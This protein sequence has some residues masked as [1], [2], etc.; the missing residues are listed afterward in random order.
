MIRKSFEALLFR[1]RVAGRRPAVH[2]GARASAR[3]TVRQS[4]APNPISHVNCFRA[5]KRRKRRAPIVRKRA[6]RVVAQITHHASRR[7]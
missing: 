2:P 1:P 6:S 4:A 5:L 3:F 7:P